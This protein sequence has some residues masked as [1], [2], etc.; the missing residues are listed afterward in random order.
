[1]TNV[2]ASTYQSAYVAA[3]NKSNFS[4]NSIG[5]FGV[6]V[7]ALTADSYGYVTIV[8][9]TGFGTQFG[10]CAPNGQLEESGGG[11][12]FMINPID[13]V[14]PPNYPTLEQGTLPRVGY[15]PKVTK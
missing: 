13:A 4:V 6:D 12:Y 9:G 7:S 5:G 1:P 11:G 2:Y 14:Y 10:T 15:W 3:I 8:W